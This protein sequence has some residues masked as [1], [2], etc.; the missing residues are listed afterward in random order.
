MFFNFEMVVKTDNVT[1]YKIGGSLT[2]ENDDKEMFDE[3]KEAY[4]E[5]LDKEG[6]ILKNHLVIKDDCILFAG[7]DIISMSN[8]LKQLSTSLG[9]KV[10]PVVIKGCKFTPTSSEPLFK[11]EVHRLFR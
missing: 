10:T 1:K 9:F 4:Q 2:P 11:M 7:V 8:I 6:I 3:L 5:L